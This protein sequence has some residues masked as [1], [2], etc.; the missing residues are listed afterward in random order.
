MSK[1]QLLI[2]PIATSEYGIDSDDRDHKFVAEETR[3]VAAAVGSDDSLPW[4]QLMA[5]TSNRQLWS[6]QVAAN[7]GG[8]EVSPEVA[9][10][11]EPAAAPSPIYPPETPTVEKRVL[12]KIRLFWAR[13]IFNFAINHG[14]QKG[15]G[16]A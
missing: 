9:Y 7:P 6:R 5:P 3:A 8:D 11:S 2:F 14:G 1:R 15:G 13:M 16:G 10:K 4:K 12:N